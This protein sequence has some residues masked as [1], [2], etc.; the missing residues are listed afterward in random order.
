MYGEQIINVTVP[1]GATTVSAAFGPG[2][3]GRVWSVGQV[4]VSMPSAPLGAVCKITKNGAFVTF[5]I[6]TG[7]VAGQGPAMTLSGT[8][9]FVVT[10]T[11]VTAGLNGSVFVVYDDG[12]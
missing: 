9:Q 4:S 12:K 1:T 6:P 10:W 11:G 8:E 5:L 2:A 3:R 7:D